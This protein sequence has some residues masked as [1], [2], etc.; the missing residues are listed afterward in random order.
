MTPHSVPASGTELLDQ[1]DADP[2]LVRIN[3]RDIAR[4]NRW[5]GGRHALSVGLRRALHDVAP[6]TRLTLLDV[7]TASGDLPSYCST[8][9][10]R[11]G[12]TFTSVGLE[13]VPAAARVAAEDGLGAF[14]GCA[15]A[16]PIG[17]KSVDVV[18]I[19]QVVHHFAH[20]E[21]ISLLRASDTVA[22]RAVI[23]VDLE[24]SKMAKAAFRIA[25]RVL[26]F[27][28]VSRLDGLTSIDRGLTTDTARA[29]FADAGI[30]ANID[31]VAPY[32]VIATWSPKP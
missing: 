30:A 18:L 17:P 23:V 28:P 19:S 31:E 7:G 3:L 16:L 22:R 5:L 12:L 2:D 8:W 9:G 6:G 27:A 32:R 25:C 4:A 29:L 24:R 15:S 10:A 11:R 21:A 20:D 26:R 13:R 14:V 1:P